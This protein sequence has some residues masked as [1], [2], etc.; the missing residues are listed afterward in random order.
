[1]RWYTE[2]HPDAAAAA[3]RAGCSLHYRTRL[4]MIAFHAD[5]TSR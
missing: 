2:K 1:M 5:A 4:S 3:T